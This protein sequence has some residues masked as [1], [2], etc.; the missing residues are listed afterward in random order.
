MNK[1]NKNYTTQ[2]AWKLIIDELHLKDKIEKNNFVK[3]SAKK[4]KE[5]KEPR[6]MCKWDSSY[7]RPK[8]LR[9][10]NISILPISRREYVL[11]NFDLYCKFPELDKEIATKIKVPHFESINTD[12]ISSEAKAISVINL[13]GILEDFLN[14]EDNFSTFAGKMG[15]GKFNFDVK[16]KNGTKKINIQVDKSICEIDAGYENNDSVVIVEA[17]NVVN[18]DFHV[19]QLYYPYR[20]W[21]TI[22]SKP[23]RLVFAVYTNKIFRLYEYRFKDIQDISSIELVKY[24]LYSIDSTDIQIDEIKVIHKKTNIE[25]DDNMSHF[26]KSNKV[27]FIQ[28]DSFDKVISLIENL[29]DN[30]MNK[31]EV[32]EEVLNVDP[33]QSDYYF[34]AAR[35]IGLLKKNSKGEM[36]LTQLGE[37]MMKMSYKQRVII[38]LQ[39]IFKHKIFYE[40]FEQ[41]INTGNLPSQIE[42]IE[43]MRD[44]NVCSEKVINR[45]SKSVI[46]WLNWIIDLPKIT[47][48]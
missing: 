45:R 33:R 14:V 28:A 12:T 23:I 26:T 9:E 4:I 46:S 44:Y 29:Y 6:V 13:S 11:G 18:S 15:V 19:R 36:I 8:I 40:S 34:N 17:K 22:V 41:Y 43:K 48:K 2:E 32:A 39:Q 20:L 31:F 24:K 30:P 47:S 3:V 7:Q 1:M 42:I 25:T 27:P 10:N 35:Y 38:M 37:K 16:L 21:D 5:Y